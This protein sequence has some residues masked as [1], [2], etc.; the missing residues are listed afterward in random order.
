MPAIEYE[1]S[2]QIVDFTAEYLQL[3]RSTVPAVDASKS[4]FKRIDSEE[5]I[6]MQR[7]LEK[8]YFPPPQSSCG[9][10]EICAASEKGFSNVHVTS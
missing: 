9:M 1:T 10:E 3:L 8:F 5:K 2:Q 4:S 6:E 7:G